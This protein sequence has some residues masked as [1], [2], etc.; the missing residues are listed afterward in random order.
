MKERLL[1]LVC[2][3]RHWIF[4]ILVALIV[5]FPFQGSRG[6][7]ET[8]EGR[9]AE[10]ARE[11]VE[12][13]NFIEPMLDYAHHWTK[14]P[15]TYWA[16][17]GGITL[18]GSNE[19]G[20]RL[21]NAIA[22]FL[23]IVLVASIGSLL[24]DKITGLAAGLVYATSP[25][26]F[27]GSNAVTTDTLL[28]L[29]EVGAVFC[30]LKSCRAASPGERKRWIFTLWVCFAFGFLTKGPP[31]LIPLIPILTWHL[32][33][34]NQ[35]RLAYVP[36]LLFFLLI[37]FS[38]Y[39]LV[40]YRH[41]ELLSYFLG[42]EVVNRVSSAAV[43]NAE[44]YKPFAIYLPALLFGAGFWA[45]FGIRALVKNHLIRYA[46][47]KDSLKRGGRSSF[48]LLWLLLP[49]LLFFVVRS[50]LV[51][52]VL[53]LY[54][55]VAL[56]I[57]RLALGAAKPFNFRRL[58]LIALIAAAFLLTAKSLA[59]LYPS[60]TDM[61]YLYD[62][63]LQ[64]S[65]DRGNKIAFSSR[66]LYGLQ[67]YLGGHLKRI[68]PSHESEMLEVILSGDPF[69]RDIIVTEAEQAGEVFRIFERAGIPFQETTGRCWRL[70]SAVHF[71]ERLA[72]RLGAERF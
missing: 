49:L 38:W 37:G 33:N 59:S 54:A 18:L 17:A 11:M 45:Y 1:L 43:R 50:R 12:T 22:F 31:A 39:V 44:W 3:K 61:R 55:P 2:R 65:G 30:Y 24:W 10:C 70:F 56:A 51:L 19:W 48:L 35:A 71:P 26:P 52:Y 63:I 62:I 66:K 53:P 6:L 9:Y 41:P 23:T 47:I 13:G 25:F 46:V 72:A 60:K 28:T 68:S 7:Y 40:E 20:V 34:K 27:F 29:W 58:A 64:V 5:A 16:I 8:S 32:W 21:Y 36:G 42:T 4:L 67:F 57:S 15:L 69:S 14:P